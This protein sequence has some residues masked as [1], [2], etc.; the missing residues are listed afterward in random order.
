MSFTTKRI[1]VSLLLS[2]SLAPLFAQETEIQV[3]FNSGLFA[4][5][6]K[7]TTSNTHLNYSEID[8]FRVTNN[9]NSNLRALSYG[10][11]VNAKKVMRPN[12]LFG[13]DLGLEVLRNSVHI[14]SVLIAT[15]NSYEAEGKSNLNNYFLNFFPYLGYRF[16]YDKW[17]LDLTAG[18]DFGMNLWAYEKGSATT[19]DGMVYNISATRTSV[20]FD[21]RPRFQLALR[22]DKVGIYGGYSFGQTNYHADIGPFNGCYASYFR[23]GLTCQ[24]YQKYYS[25]NN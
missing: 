24:V 1:A 23:F 10:V 9:P 3:Q 2:L 20:P 11:S 16:E 13:A 17:A 19:S 12:L 25:I 21:F 6:G 22:Y 4:F 15:N 18:F 7:T 14:T 8:A 5:E